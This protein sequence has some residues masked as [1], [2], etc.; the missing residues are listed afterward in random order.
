M[1][2]KAFN[3]DNQPVVIKGKPYIRLSLSSGLAV[4][5]QSAGKI[6][7]LTE[8]SGIE[9]CQNQDVPTDWYLHVTKSPP[10]FPVRRKDQKS[11]YCFNNT[12]VIKKLFGELKFEGKSCSFPVSGT[13]EIVDGEEYFFIISRQPFNIK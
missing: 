13:P 5:S 12:S 2:L 10:G 7:G 8:D 1:K 11:P 9:L 6:I 3:Q 4:I